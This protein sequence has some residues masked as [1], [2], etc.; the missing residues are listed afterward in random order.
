M[1]NKFYIFL[2][3]ALFNSY[4]FSQSIE[5]YSVSYLRQPIGFNQYTLDGGFMLN[6]RQKLLNPNNFG[7]GGT[8]AKPINITDDYVSAGSLMQVSNI[9]KFNLFLF[10]AFNKA[11]ASLLQFTN[12]EIDS[13]YEWSKNGGKLIIC[14]SAPVGGYSADILNSK[15]G[16]QIIDSVPSSYQ[17][18]TLGLS[19]DIFNGPFGNVI[20]AN[21]GGSAQGYF[22]NMPANSKIFATEINGNP[23]FFMDCNTLD[24]IIADVDGFTDL[25]G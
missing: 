16:F 1:K 23:T 6:S 25:G 7:I 8:Y 22:I 20:A 15:W 3:C 18:N 17:P 14:G 21:Q 9:P 24:L 10:G 2:I 13:L 12:E 4:A 5:I 19:T 11:E